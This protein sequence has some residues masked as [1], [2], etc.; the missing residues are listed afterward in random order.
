M[1]K[2]LALML[3]AVMILAIVS[4]GKIS[5]EDTTKA[6]DTTK[7]ETTGSEQ[8]TSPEEATDPEETTAPEE[9]TG[10]PEIPEKPDATLSELIDKIYEIHPVDVFVMTTEC[11][12][13][14]ADYMKYAIGLESVDKASEACTSG[15]MISAQAYELA[16]VRVKDAADA[17]AVAREML[18]GADPGKWICVRAE[19]VQVAV[20]GDLILMVMSSKEEA[21]GLVDAFKTVCGGELDFVLEK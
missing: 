21:A 5:E 9:T 7:P 12:L 11:D 18:E 13:G 16:L 20:S 17:E 14:D 2:L 19:S 15:P 4:C 3:A 8:T 6:S 10:E 1:K